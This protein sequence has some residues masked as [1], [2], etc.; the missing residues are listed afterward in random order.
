MRMAVDQAGGDPSP[1]ERV[2][3]ARAI[4][5]E[6]RALAH[7][8]D[9]AV[10]DPNGAILDDPLGVPSSVAILQSTSSRSH[11]RRR[12]RRAAVLASKPW[13]FGRT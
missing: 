1:A 6:L 5:R 13:R 8:H 10:R 4:T 7:A 11:M 9:L 12:L 3:L 2:H